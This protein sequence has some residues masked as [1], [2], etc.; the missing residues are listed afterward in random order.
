MTVQVKIEHT[1]ET[2][3]KNLRVD[4]IEGD[5]VVDSLPIGPGGQRTFMIH[6]KRWIRITEETTD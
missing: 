4:L 6:G 5:K 2:V 1:N 3:A